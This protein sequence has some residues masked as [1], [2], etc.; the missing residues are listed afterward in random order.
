[1]FADG[2]VGSTGP[3]PQSALHR[4]VGVTQGPDGSLYF[5]DDVGGR[6]YRVIYR[7]N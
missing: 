1:V 5:S 4:P 6:I 7:G 3:L 2:F